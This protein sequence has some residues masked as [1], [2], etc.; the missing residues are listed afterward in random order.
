MDQALLPYKR[1]P[2]NIL[3]KYLRD[4]AIGESDNGWMTCQTFFC[5]HRK[6]FLSFLNKREHKTACDIVYP[7]LSFVAALELHASDLLNMEKNS[8][9]Q[10]TVQTDGSLISSTPKTQA[11]S[12][13]VI[14]VVAEPST[15]SELVTLNNN[16]LSAKAPVEK[17][18]T[19]EKIAPLTELEFQ[20]TF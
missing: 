10:A 15:E 12:T 20:N 8:S 2:Q 17:M 13:V 11:S 7:F 5:V 9:F 3:S 1:L 16:N 18:S 19:P 14:E 4:W 6:C